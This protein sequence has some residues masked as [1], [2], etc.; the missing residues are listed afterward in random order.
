MFTA[1]LITKF[2]GL[3]TPFYY[4]DTT[5]LAN[6]LAEVKRHADAYQFTVHYAVK[7]NTNPHLMRQI[8]GAGLGADCVSGNEITQALAV[9][10]KPEHIVFAGVGKSDKEILTALEAD[11]FCFNSESVQEL[12]IIN[13]LAEKTGKIARIALRLNPNVKADTHKYITTG[14][15]ENKFGIS[16]SQLDLVIQTLEK[17][18]FLELVGVHF[19]IGSQIVDLEN[20]KTLC[21]RL[22]EIQNT[23]EAQY[24]P[25]QHINV[26]G[27]LGI[28]YRSPEQNPM[29]NFEAYFKIF[30]ENV[31]RRPE[32]QIHFELG[33]SII[34]QCGSL[35]TKVLYLKEGLKKKFIIADAGMN[36]LIRPSLYQAYHKIENLTSDSQ[37]WELYDVVGPVCESADCFD[38]NVS[39]PSTQRGDLLAIRSAGAYGE[40]M[41]STYNLRDRAKSYY[42]DSL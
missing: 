4:Y 33:R 7:A 24:F 14:L 41:I 15:E 29:A 11:I 31:E 20:F 32:Q 22:N 37:N 28:D 2:K 19:H 8:A 27:G 6:T 35:I 38:K 5:L 42:L 26:G 9:G 36:D 1:S 25:L 17:C 18:N 39:L 23:F 13:Q 3:E 16:L 34:G 40:V 10:F 12:E 21:L 30:A